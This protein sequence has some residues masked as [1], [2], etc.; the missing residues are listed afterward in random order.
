MK[1][2]LMAVIIFS[3]ISLGQTG[4]YFDAPFGGGGGYTPGWYMPKVD[5]VNT[6]LQ[7]FGVPEIT[8]GGF[9]TSGGAGYIYIAFVPYMRIGGM[10]YGGSTSRS[11]TTPDGFNREVIYTLGGGGFTLEYTLP[12]IKRVAVSVGAILGGGNLEICFYR[13][14]GDFNWNDIWNESSGGTASEDISRT[15]NRNFFFVSP[16]L[17]ADIPVYRFITLRLGVGYQMTFGGKW[18]IDND[19]PLNGVPADLNGN[20]FFIQ[21][22][23]FLGFFSF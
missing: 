13:N 5:I 8:S 9:Y 16:T 11:A 10:G 17:N 23:I 22:G 15:L 20:S 3:F 1:Q 4:S 18:T 14:R 19:R 7:N 2:V 6:Q 21:S 12:F